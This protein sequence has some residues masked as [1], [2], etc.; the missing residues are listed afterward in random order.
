MS[1]GTRNPD[2]LNPADARL[3]DLERRRGLPLHVGFVLVF[4][5]DAPPA[6]AL[7]EH[8]AQR[9]A[10]VPRF[11]R[12]VVEVPLRQGRPVWA[13]DPHLHLAY[14]VRRESLPGGD[15][16][17][18]ARLA[19]HLFSERLDR[20]RPL[21]ELTVVEGLDADRF[22]LI[23]KSHA[24]LA[25]EHDGDPDIVGALLDED[26]QPPP[27]AAAAGADPPAGPL[28]SPGQLLAGAIVERA[29]A[30]GELL[31][32]LRGALLAV[33]DELGRRDL[34][35]LARLD[36][37]TPSPLNRPTGP[38]RRFA[39]LDEPF[40]LVRAAKERLGGTV[41]DV[42]LAAVAGAVGS[43]LRA[44]G[45][46]TDGLVLRALTPVAGAAEGRLL[47]AYAPLPVGLRDERRRHSEISRALDGLRDSGRAAAA[48]ALRSRAGFAPTAMI[49]A[50]AR[51]QTTQRSFNL[52]VTNAPGP[53]GARRLLGRRLAAIH[54]AMPLAPAQTLSVA[55]IS[56]GGRVCFGLLG[57]R[58]ALADPG[59]LVGFLHE[60]LLELAPREAR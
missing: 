5:G 38:Q 30:P 7:A 33:R 58:G 16:R 46:D 8:V 60:A 18:L 35:P 3:L 23:A 36:A 29:C 25:S 53:P 54:P 55:V 4:E 52:A 6:G 50:A 10:T 41:N 40:E 27:P 1:R 13:P 59:R 32:S 44:A 26:T 49:G 9:L 39:W 24:V 11:R 2:R 12:V 28:P 57:D 43:E 15:E 20:T 51:L 47:A 42:V 37:A 31:E 22:A 21:W 34:D 14:H 48:G 56:S 19:G 45:T 17:A